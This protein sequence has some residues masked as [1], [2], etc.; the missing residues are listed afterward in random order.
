M[1]SGAIALSSSALTNMAAVFG[2]AVALLLRLTTVSVAPVMLAVLRPV[3]G[4]G[5]LMDDERL[6]YSTGDWHRA[7]RKRIT[8]ESSCYYTHEKELP[9]GCQYSASKSV[10]WRSE[11]RRSFERQVLADFYESTGGENW[12]TADNWD[13]GDPCWDAWHGITCDEHGHIIAIDM[14]DNNLYGTLAASLGRLESLLKLD[15]STT[16]LSYHNHKNRFMNRIEGE[17]P[18]LKDMA[19]LEEINIAG[20]LI[21]SL[22]EDLY[23]NG[24]SLR[25]VCASYNTLTAMPRYLDR[26]KRLHT[27]ELDHN[28]IAGTLPPDIGFMPEARYIHLDSN[29]LAGSIPSTIAGLSRIRV[30]DI[31]HNPGLFSEIS[32]DVI[33]NWPEVEYLSMLNTS[34]GGYIASLC[35]DVPFC[36]KYMFDTHKDL[37]WATAADVPDIVNL[38]IELAM[39]NP[40]GPASN[41]G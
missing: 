25:L 28:S 13:V 33:V 15:I 10:A 11:G 9:Y 27:L 32:E 18:S 30:F 34:I 16:A 4:G 8:F 2:S 26:F 40:N 31:A 7:Q 17:V 14:V 5:G 3:A 23:L 37:T 35:L 36:Y 38:T 39:T 29:K 24:G 21:H 19:R 12:R 1:P 6:L 20:N 22:P 41:I